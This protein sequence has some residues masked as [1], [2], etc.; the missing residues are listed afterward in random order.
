[1]EHHAPLS[2]GIPAP[3]N[4]KKVRR[5]DSNSI[6]FALRTFFR[7]RARSGPRCGH[8]V[9]SQ[10]FIDTGATACVEAGAP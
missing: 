2:T 10:H 4:G 7:A 5:E 8:S 3:N 9:C 1:M 6:L